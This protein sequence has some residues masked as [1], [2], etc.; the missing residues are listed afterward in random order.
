M[1]KIQTRL[2]VKILYTRT[3]RN[4]LYEI[5]RE[6]LYTANTENCDVVYRVGTNP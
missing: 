1:Q 6:V 4:Q 3:I 5:D 2:Y